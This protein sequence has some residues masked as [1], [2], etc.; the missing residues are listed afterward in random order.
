MNN[1]QYST[2]T[3]L[4]TALLASLS[5]LSAQT[6]TLN[7]PSSATFN[8][9]FTPGFPL[10]PFFLPE[11]PTYGNIQEFG[12]AAALIDGSGLSGTPA[13]AN[14]TTITHATP[15]FGATPNAWASIDPGSA[16]GDFFAEVPSYQFN[17]PGGTFTFTFN[18]PLDLTDMVS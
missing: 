12:N 6:A 11:P 13:I 16:G 18:T 4:L 7:S 17:G 1:M 2:R 5:G 15:A 9:A 14:Y 10:P 8:D 3:I